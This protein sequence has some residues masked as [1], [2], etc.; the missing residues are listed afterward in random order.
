MLQLRMVLAMIIRKFD[1]TIPSGQESEFQQ[2]GDD[3]S[4]CFTIHLRPLPLFLRERVD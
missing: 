2:F 4:D 3:Q 1:I